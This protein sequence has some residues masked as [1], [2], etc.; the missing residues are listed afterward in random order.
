[1]ELPFMGRRHGAVALVLLQLASNAAFGAVGR[2]PG[3]AGVSADGES[4]YSI[5]L[6][7]PPGTN[8][9]TPQLSL[10]YRHR[11]A[12]GLL[13]IG[14]SIGGLSQ[15]ARCPRTIAQDGLAAPVPK[16]DGE[17]FCLDGQR[18]VSAS[19]L[20]YDTPGS[21]YRT[22]IESFAR[23]RSIAGAGAS[24]HYFVVE[25]ADGRVLEYGATADS[26]IDWSA[27][28]NPVNW[29]RTWALSRIRDRS[30]NVIDF[31][32]AENTANGSFRIAELRY[33]S[34]PAAGVAASH[35]VAFV[36][37]TR[38]NNE[39]DSAY[40]PG[41]PIRQVVRLDRIDVLHETTVLR[42]Y[43][44]SYQPA[45]A[46]SGY[47][48]LASIHE[49]GR[50]AM[51]C[52]A[53]TTFAWQDGSAGVGPLIAYTTTMPPSGGLP[54]HL[55]VNTADINGDGRD[56]LVTLGGA[57]RNVATIRYRLAQPNGGF[58]PE[59]DSG[60]PA[61]D[62]IGVPFD[63]NADGRSDLL[64]VS[65]TQRWQIV[66]G[67]TAGLGAPISAGIVEP[68]WSSE[69]RGLDMNGDGLGDIAWL[70][71]ISTSPGAMRVRVR[72]A[73]PSGGFVAEAATLYD[74]SEV[75]GEAL[76]MGG[77]FHGRPGERID[78]DRDGTDDLILVEPYSITRITAQ[79][80]ASE[81][82]D[83]AP[84]GQTTL[85]MNGDDCEDLAYLHYTGRLRIRVGGCWPNWDGTELQGPAF[86]GNL[87]LR[88]HDWN[89]D[90]REDVL[91]RGA[92]NWHVALSNGDSFTT[93]IDT[94]IPH[95][96]ATFAVGADFN[97][98]GLRDLLTR[99]GNVVRLRLRNGPKANLLISATD[100]FGVAANFS[101]RPLTDPSVYARGADAAFPEQAI[102]SGAYVVATL[103]RT[104]GSGTGALLRS[105]YAYEGLRRHLHG[106]GSL[107]FAK[108]TTT[109]TGAGAAQAV[110]E[111]F[112]Q[113]YPF[114]GL[115]VSVVARQL[116]GMPISETTYTWS[117][118]SLGSV[119]YLR[120]FPYAS[121]INV[122]RREAGGVLDGSEIAALTRTVAAI[123]PVS[124]LATDATT[125]ITEL[126]GG[127]HAGSSASLRTLHTGVLND[128]SNWC[129]GR[130]LATQ[131]I[132][133][134]TLP[135][136]NAATRSFDQDWDAE[137]CRPTQARR[138][139]GDNQWQV[140]LQLAYDAFGNI[141]SRSVTGAGMS[142]RTT[143][144]QWNAR[145]Q[146]LTG[147][148]NPL[149]Q[150]FSF[151]WDPGT[152]LPTAITDPNALTVS[153]S[154]D[155]HGRLAQENHPQG[156]RSTWVRAAC[157]SG[158]DARTRYRV[159]QSDRDSAGVTQVTTSVDVDQLDRG[160]RTA[161][162]LPGGGTSVLQMDADARGRESRRYLPYWS[163]GT[164]PGHWQT[165]YDPL[166]RPAAISLHAADGTLKRAHTLRHD[167]HSVSHV[168]ALGRTTTGT[169]T[170]WGIP[171]QVVDPA[172]GRTRYE[173]DAWGGLLRVYDAQDN[174]AMS[175]AYNA[176]GMPVSQA[177]MN[178]GTWTY[179]HDALGELTSLR[180][181]KSQMTGFAY[182]ALGRLTGR[183][184]PDGTS[185]LTWGASAASRNIGRLASISG[186]G[187]A[188]SYVYDGS[189]RLATRTIAS[190]QN[191]RYDFAYN[192]FG[193]PATL[194]YPAT[195]GAA[196]F[197]LAFDYQHGQLTGIRDAAAPAVSYWT[198]GTL[199]AA[200][201]VIDETRGS[202][203]RV[204]SGFDP[205]TGLMDYRRASA[206]ASAIQDLSYAWDGNDNLTQRRDLRQG[207]TEDFRYDALDRLDDSRRNGT[208]NL[209]L[210]YDLLGNI[211]WK[212]DVCPTAAACYTYHAT[213]RHAAASVAGKSYAYDANGNMTNRAGATIGWNSRNLPVSIAGTSGNA[214]QFSYGPF[215]NRW[216][217]VASHSGTTETTFYAGELMEKVV[218]AG[219]TTWRHYIPAPGGLAAVHLRYGNGSPPATRYLT[220]D[221]QGSTDRILDGNGAVLVSESYSPFGSRRG[222][223][224]NGT[225]SAAELAAIADV[226]RDG[227]T[228][229]EHLDNLGLIHM[230]GRVY[231][232][233]LGRFLSADPHVTAPF[234]AQSLN[235][236]S[237]VWNNPLSLVDPGGFDPEQL[238]CVQSAPNTCARI[239]VI[240]VEWDDIMRAIFF[241][242]GAM[243]AAGGQVI[244]ASQRDPC[245]QE[246]S[247]LACVFQ[248]G[249]PARPASVVLTVG[250][251]VDSTLSRNADLDRLQGFAARVANL[252]ISASPV[253][254]LFGADPDFEWFDIPDTAAGR[255]GA[256]IGNAGYLIGGIAG[257][258][259][260]TGSG[261]AAA[262]VTDNAAPI[263]IGENMARVAAYASRIGGDFFA[264]RGMAA[265]QA[266]IE[267][268]RDA[269]RKIIDIGPD[270]ERRLTRLMNDRRLDSIYYNMERRATRG[271]QS[272]QTV[273][274]R[275]G[276]HWGDLVGGP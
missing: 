251:Q 21:E 91:L 48:R 264:G 118:L 32:Y 11:S 245:G 211:R 169:R 105:D 164:P 46:A 182:D 213:R 12:G 124:G 3:F 61:R 268:A 89:D 37:E 222:P 79:A 167:G 215:G 10:E 6:R 218:R 112:R 135:G 241:T 121:V 275:A 29:A 142:P 36:Y 42:R 260:R 109:E 152:G 130:P 179:M 276:K 2:T 24:P 248:G 205:L 223:A 117:S 81:G 212:S 158:C 102:Q 270:F 184:A 191:Y 255:A 15:I 199:D 209:D 129:L 171:S 168:D 271:Y 86:T 103:A 8:G 44:L 73:L 247:A 274:Q 38:P 261:L 196:R 231:D 65:A 173:N 227:F 165:A 82:F 92:A 160:F 58:G 246:S 113:D 52:F 204:I 96:H 39:I 267:A 22:E 19:G 62:G 265:N 201:N 157:T 30:G 93:L 193:L 78:F 170:A 238:P 200:G 40:V 156:T 64:M 253:T 77:S 31:L 134:H 115:P 177:E 34:N 88:T 208:I 206:G 13:G 153:W 84:T 258:V 128:T 229:H 120:R 221:H 132:A 181:A 150:S 146:L 180:D 49:C 154:Y 188:E 155:A 162:I 243:G 33:N 90:G 125:T 50:G 26:R 5:P 175:V 249:M 25:S 220:Q 75:T 263:V 202:L 35:R 72:Y 233:L 254:W 59:I 131:V 98:D 214:S 225:P 195:T 80:Y 9:M 145:G 126:A 207:I 101:Y 217:Q 147:V 18:L 250:T 236:Y 56:D 237:Y 97:G 20:P 107:G 68:V 203:L 216:Q 95:D 139:P 230:G 67:T 17:R 256:N 176:V 194:T 55:L 240:G 108:R 192:G 198:L 266:W 137:K 54:D 269:G 60:I 1:M 28:A 219:A 41:T 43:E 262:A 187:Y 242:G 183:T 273:W 226:T 114:T 83:G 259:R 138:A 228:G 148:T 104:D 123:D 144:F 161:T 63:Y 235:R 70:E 71:Q 224:W 232:P 239:T 234:N 94:G 189:G 197:V 272:L 23:I 16:S 140:A 257:T 51:D 190:D 45:L 163:G 141:A 210:D 122:R 106:R 4:S 110:V 127:V 66:P 174:L 99:T 252:A 119:P 178:S 100:G 14:W 116:S 57:S 76:L 244:S 7:L 111:S 87:Y 166:G 69:Y 159:T 85:D 136:G 186:P 149:Q 172:A 47:S 53:P 74:Q 27:A 143:T 133:S 185:T 151:G